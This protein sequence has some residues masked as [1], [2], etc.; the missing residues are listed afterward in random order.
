M[1][2]V[3][4]TPFCRDNAV[5]LSAP[6]WKKPVVLRTSSAIDSS[7]AMTSWSRQYQQIQRGIPFSSASHVPFDILYTAL[8]GEELVQVA[9]CLGIFFSQD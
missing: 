5:S 3:R 6:L 1:Q 8:L 4:Q 2:L 9:D 7:F